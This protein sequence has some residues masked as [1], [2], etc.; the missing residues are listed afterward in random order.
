MENKCKKNQSNQHKS[1]QKIKVMPKCGK[2]NQFGHSQNTDEDYHNSSQY[3]EK[4][5]RVEKVNNQHF[6][7]EKIDSKNLN[8][9][10]L[11]VEKMDSCSSQSK[12]DLD[13]I[14]KFSNQQKIYKKNK[15]KNP[16]IVN[17]IRYFGASQNSGDIDNAT[18]CPQL[19]D[20]M[21]LEQSDCSGLQNQIPRLHKLIDAVHNKNG[22]DILVEDNNVN[23]DENEI[24][25]VN[26]FRILQ[27]KL[28]EQK[29]VSFE[30]TKVLLEEKEQIPENYWQAF[31]NML[32]HDEFFR[33]KD[34]RKRY[35]STYV[36]VSILNNVSLEEKL[37]K[38]EIGLLLIGNKYTEMKYDVDDKVNFIGK[39]NYH[40]I[41]NQD[42]QPQIK[43]HLFFSVLHQYDDGKQQNSKKE[44]LQNDNILI[45]EP[46]ANLQTTKIIKSVKKE[47]QLIQNTEEQNEFEC[48]I[49]LK[50]TFPQ[51]EKVLA[52]SEFYTEGESFALCQN[53]IKSQ[54]YA[55]LAEKIVEEQNKC[56]TLRFRSIQNQVTF[57][58][59]NVQSILQ[60]NTGS[61]LQWNVEPN[62]LEYY[63]DQR[64]NVLNLV[65]NRIMNEKQKQSE[66]LKWDNLKQWFNICN[67]GRFSS[68]ALKQ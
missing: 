64:Q 24:N 65:L 5:R 46:Y 12:E 21:E 36:R 66:Q 48:V 68:K 17:K 26:E 58:Q 13:F 25:Q 10:L 39:F 40:I 33:D 32:V 16:K 53:D 56:I 49:H 1:S 42:Q 38:I 61:S 51:P 18:Y 8:E 30:I 4:K 62:N 63:S 45:V 50:K 22:E 47:E 6:Q 54:F 60:S 27:Q 52:I 20:K 59:K 28:N 3:P 11:I 41:V 44:V 2:N 57:N 55:V 37:R 31:Q 14:E 29:Y 19:F 34:V 35:T 9:Y 15:D 23:L 43:N 67:H 7:S